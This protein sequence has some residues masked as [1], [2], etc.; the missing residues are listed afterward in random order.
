MPEHS[1]RENRE[2]PAVSDSTESERSANADGGTAD[3][4]AAGKSDELVVPP[5]RSTR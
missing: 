4:D 5:T 3:V 1:K 2:I